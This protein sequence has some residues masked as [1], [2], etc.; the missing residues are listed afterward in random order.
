MTFPATPSDAKS[1]ALRTLAQNLGF[2]VLL[3]VVLVA[4]PLVQAEHVDYGLILASVIKTAVVTA[5]AFIQRSL[6]TRRA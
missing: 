3:A 5:L 6:E 4:L 2:D 1:R